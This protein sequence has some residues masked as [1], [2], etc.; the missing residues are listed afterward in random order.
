MVRVQTGNLKPITAMKCIAILSITFIATLLPFFPINSLFAQSS[1]N[2]GE[3]FIEQAAF[4]HNEA[5]VQF[6]RDFTRA[7]DLTPEPF[8]AESPIDPLAFVRQFGI[9]NATT[10]FQRGSSHRAVLHVTGADNELNLEQNGSGNSA[11]INLAGINNILDY[12]QRGNGNRMNIN[13]LGFGLE[14]QLNQTG[15]NH[16][17]EVT[18][19][20][21]PLQVSQTGNGASVFIE[22]Y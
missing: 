21:I 9:G 10:L 6:T 3:A 15:T 11:E 19:I 2:P 20:G 14:Q 12:S 5:V 8:S 22:T 17:M 18:G 4:N 13:I 7:S 16:V 1:A